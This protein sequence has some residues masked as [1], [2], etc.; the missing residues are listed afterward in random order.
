MT[1]LNYVDKRGIS[2]PLLTMKRL[3]K[4][5]GRQFDRPDQLEA[6]GSGHEVMD[7]GI[8]TR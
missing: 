1:A 7:T 3:R 2:D 5:S 8:D 6:T 4:E